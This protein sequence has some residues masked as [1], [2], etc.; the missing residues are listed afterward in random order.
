MEL[1]FRKYFWTVNLVFILL[2][3]WMVARTANLFVESAIA[4]GLGSEQMARMPQRTHAATQQAMLDME[5]LSRLTGIKIPEP[6]VAVQEPSS[7]PPVDEN[8][9]PVKS[10]LRVKLLGTLVAADKLWSFA[11]VQDM[12]T[13]RS[14]T[15]MVGDRIQG[16]EV[17]DILRER[18]IILN[19]GRREFID[20]QPGD[21]AAPVPTYPPPA[22]ATA[23]P[24]GPPNNGLGNGIRS[25][26]ENE[27]EVP[28]TEID[29]TLSNL[30]EVAMQARI[31]P[32][33][34]DG[35]AQGFKLFS[36]R[37]D[38]IYS[39]IGVQNGDVIRRINGFELNSPEKALEVYSKLKEAGRIEIEIERNGA[40]IRKTYNVR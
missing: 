22:V 24:A 5:T 35:Q 15:Y 9:E 33:F 40:P 38:S 37:P 19:N 10:G 32:A 4:P 2:V 31:V 25:T 7:A 27:Y 3:A 21:G 16:A 13:Q 11:S 28:R 34:K 20:G 12:G 23:P 18:V 29:R 36:I 30:N 17:T 39:K 6:E 26:G 8:A 1:F 14:Q